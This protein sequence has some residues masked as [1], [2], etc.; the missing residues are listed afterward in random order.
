MM[1]GKIIGLFIECTLQVTNNFLN[2]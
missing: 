2:S 1:F